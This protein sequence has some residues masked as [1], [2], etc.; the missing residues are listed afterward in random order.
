MN[1]P[2]FPQIILLH[3][4]EDTPD[5][6]VARLHGILSAAYPKLSYARP[7][8]PD[9][10][11]EDAV[12]WV[13][14]QYVRRIQP[15][16]LLVGFER[17]GLIACAIQSRFPALRLSVF[18]INSPTKE[19]SI[20]ATYCQHTYSRVALYS[21]EYPHIKG[22]CNWPELQPMAYDVPWLANGHKLDYPISYLISA[23]MRGADMEKEVALMFPIAV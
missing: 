11:I 13:A 10:M 3:G 15:N 19:G 4:R 18:A 6:A 9:A 23:Y 22:R 2:M 1:A 20:S 7:F 8:I 16:S 21:S 14:N 12:E 5:G 17:G